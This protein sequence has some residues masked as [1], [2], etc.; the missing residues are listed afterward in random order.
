MKLGTKKALNTLHIQIV[1]L[2]VLVYVC[3]VIGSPFIRFV[4]DQ[5][6]LTII[7]VLETAFFGC[8]YTLFRQDVFCQQGV[9]QLPYF[10]LIKQAAS[11][12]TYLLFG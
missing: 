6:T 8:Q 7:Y 5:T 2:L 11:G 1:V 4:E 12:R 9:G 3:H 10:C